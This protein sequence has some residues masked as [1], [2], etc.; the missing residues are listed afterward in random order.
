MIPADGGPEI[1]GGKNL[2][3]DGI[4]QDGRDFA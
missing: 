3:L 4:G 2:V 1:Q